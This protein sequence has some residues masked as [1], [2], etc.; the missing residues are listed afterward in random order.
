VPFT[1]PECHGPLWELQHG[2]LVRY[3]CRVGH[4]Y[5]EDVLIA[6]KANAVE[7][8]LWMA[9]EALEERTDLLGKVAQR[10][11]GE[12]RQAA[13]DHTRERARGAAER[14]ELIRGVL[15]I[16]DDAGE[17]VAAAS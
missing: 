16:D 2:D 15:H 6:G 1:C 11:E 8:A 9:V 4:V 10:L 12:G 17:D 7:A 14:A 5:G 13:A 3:R